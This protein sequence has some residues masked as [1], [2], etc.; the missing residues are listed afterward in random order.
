[1]SAPVTLHGYRYSVYTRI[2]RIVL[3]EKGVACRTEQIDPFARPPPADLLALHPFARAPVLRHADFTLYE[4]AAIARYVD[5]AFPGPALVL[6]SPCAAASMAQTICLID[7]HADRPLVRRV[8]SRAV[9]RPAMGAPSPRPG[10]CSRR[11]TRSP[12][13]PPSSTAPPSP[14]PT[15]NSPR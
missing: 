4:T 9:L 3:F 14:W 11:S 12:R 15:A 5:A 1:M 6:P 8:F 7:A 10:R 13:K 2:A